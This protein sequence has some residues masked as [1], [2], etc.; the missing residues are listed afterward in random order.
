MRPSAIELSQSSL[1]P[2]R[3]E[4][5]SLQRAL[6]VLCWYFSSYIT[7]SDYKSAKSDSPHHSVLLSLL[8][9][10]RQSLARAILYDA[11]WTQG[12]QVRLES[13]INDRL[14][15]IFRLHGAVDHEPPLFLPAVAGQNEEA[16][17]ALF[18]DRQ[19]DLVSL[20]HDSLFSFAR[21]AALSKVKRIKRYHIGNMY[22]FK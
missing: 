3:L 13:K 10:Q 4:D 9:E 20:P 12:D 8:F 22:R 21:S 18:F 19:G 1:L 5:E 7:D 6:R 17:S 15:Y 14:S 16:Y 11:D 2:P